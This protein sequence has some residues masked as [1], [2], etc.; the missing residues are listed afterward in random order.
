MDSPFSHHDQCVEGCCFQYVFANALLI[1]LQSPFR[2]HQDKLSKGLQAFR[3]ARGDSLWQ[4]DII[5]RCSYV[6]LLSS[7]VDKYLKFCLQELT[8]ESL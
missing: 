5:C 6:A 2:S 1:C 7:V 8:M 4:A 3:L